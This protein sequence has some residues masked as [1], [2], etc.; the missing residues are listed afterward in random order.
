M[1]TIKPL[2]HNQFTHPWST[3]E[4]NFVKNNIR[5]MTYKEMGK[6][7]SRTS[8]SIQSKV[9][10]LDTKQKVKKYDLNQHFFEKW[11]EKMAYV[12]GFITADGNICK[13]GRSHM[14]QIACDDRDVIEKI[15]CA[16]SS[17][18]PIHMRSRKNGKVSYQLRI[19]DIITYNNLRKLGIKPR[20]SLDITP[21]SVP[22]KYLRHYF[23]GF[24][25]GDGSVW[26]S[27]RT[28]TK[29]LVTVFYSAS[30]S[31]AKFIYLVIRHICVDYKGKLQ[32]I[33]TPR[34]N[35]FYF[36][37]VLGHRD[38]LLVYNFMYKQASIFM[39]RKYRKYTDL[40]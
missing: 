2:T 25:D 40:N 5:K 14:L 30:F 32:K 13:S 34:K 8:S 16:M 22:N 4:I 23:R 3:E 15:K 11:N 20:K 33:R 19:S 28:S 29:R 31:M 9:R 17:S 38:S 24:F 37:I 35:N 6:Y 1:N 39:D 21:A 18:S 12:L 26:V 10:F 36:S 27:N 7:I